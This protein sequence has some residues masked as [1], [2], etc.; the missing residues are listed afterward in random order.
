M[1]FTVCLDHKMSTPK[2]IFNITSSFLRS[3]STPPQAFRAA[4]TEQTAKPSP[5]L[6]ESCLAVLVG[7]S[8]LL[9]IATCHPL[10][11][12]SALKQSLCTHKAL[13]TW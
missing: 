11:H 8:F 5:G 7:T 13:G 3:A 6:D 2:D 9:Y 12:V 10:Q 4:E 1:I